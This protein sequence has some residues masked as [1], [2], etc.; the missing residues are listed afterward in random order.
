MSFDF[1]VGH[2][3]SLGLASHLHDAAID[4]ELDTFL[5]EAGDKVLAQLLG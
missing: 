5:A 3:D 2:V 4:Q 1:A